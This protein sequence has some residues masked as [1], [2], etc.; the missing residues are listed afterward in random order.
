VHSDEVPLSC[1]G[2]LPDDDPELV[3]PLPDDGPPDVLEPLPDDDDPELLEPL[4]D[5]GAPELLEPLSDDGPPDVLEAL[6]DDNGAELPESPPDDDP[7]TPD[8]D[9][10]PPSE[11]EQ[12]MPTSKPKLTA[13]KRS[14]MGNLEGETGIVFRSGG[15]DWRVLRPTFGE[16]PPQS[17]GVVRAHLG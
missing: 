7:A 13:R 14:V 15:F 9:W 10:L 17:A 8:P 12:A 4:P 3:E 16:R 2:L 6:P 11:A 1:S 5:D